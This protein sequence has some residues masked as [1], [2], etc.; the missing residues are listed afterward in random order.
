M[1]FVYILQSESNGRFYIGHAEDLVNRLDEH[2]RGES[3]STRN[4]GPW[5]L[6]YSE[7]FPTK[8][9]AQL[10]EYEIKS[11]KSAKASEG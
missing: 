3:K 11:K 8:S 5:Q 1:F 10:R 9:D 2:N 7:T 6:V 4:R